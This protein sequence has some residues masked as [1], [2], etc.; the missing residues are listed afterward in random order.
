MT[1]TPSPICHDLYCIKPDY[2]DLNVN[3]KL[4]NYLKL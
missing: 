1:S 2:I 3:V 4:Y